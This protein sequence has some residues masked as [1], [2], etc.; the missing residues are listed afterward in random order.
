MPAQVL[1]GGM[2]NQVGPVFER[3]L[4]ERTG[5]RG[6]D[7][8]SCMGSSAP[9]KRC[10]GGQVGD[11]RQRVR[12]ALTGHDAGP[13]IEGRFKSRFVVQSHET[14]LRTEF[15]G[16]FVQQAVA[17]AVQLAK[18]DRVRARFEPCHENRVQSR[19]SR[20]EDERTLC[21]LQ[22]TNALLDRLERWIRLARVAAR[23]F[24]MAR[25]AQVVG[26]AAHTKGTASHDRSHER[27]ARCGVAG[28]P[29]NDQGAWARVRARR[30]STGWAR[31]GHR[32]PIPAVCLARVCRVHGPCRPPSR[33]PF[34]QCPATRD[35]RKRIPGRGTALVLV[36]LQS[37]PTLLANPCAHS[38]AHEPLVDLD[39]LD[40]S[41]VVYTKDDLLK[42]LK[43][44]G[45]FALLDG[46]L[47]LSPTETDFVVGYKDVRGDDWWAE[48]HIPGRPLFP[49]MLM[50]EA[51]AQLGSFDFYH[52]SDRTEGFVG[53]TAINETR[54]R[55]AVEPDCRMLFV[56]KV[57]RMRKTLFTYRFQGFVERKLVFESEV[58]GMRF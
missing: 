29:V 45:R 10:N 20:G 17:A 50:V 18:D 32:L 13:G 43:Q 46:V 2:P 48:D 40:L 38:M 55:S 23:A 52:R 8:Q 28:A 51:S 58:T 22:Q 49:G 53:F 9:Q 37:S 42:V 34:V 16:E 47:H 12:Q 11:G 3:A 54:F 19:H 39:T 15:G 31:L 33:V 14:Q 41:R 26:L 21:T 57:H 4:A 1:G 24:G 6:V 5:E 7:H 25:T 44:R 27:I 36:S 30:A 56:G 35:P